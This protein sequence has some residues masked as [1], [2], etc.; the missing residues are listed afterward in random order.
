MRFT[1]SIILICLV[2]PV[3]VFAQKTDSLVKKDFKPSGIR[4]GTDVLS[5]VRNHLDESFAGWEVSADVDF[6]RYYLA[7]DIGRWERNFT[8]ATEQYN[9]NG[10]YW[11]AGV[12]VNFLKK[13]PEKNMLFL[14][15]RYASGA[16]DEH[17]TFALDD[18]WTSGTTSYSNVNTKAS[19]AEI[20]GGLRI[21]LWKA[22]WVGYTARYK[23]GLNTKETSN[24]VPHDV[25]GFGKTNKTA[26]WGFNYQILF[27]VPF[28][29]EGGRN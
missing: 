23:F 4:I 7:F 26:T 10:S 16:F 13:D 1:S 3:M 6:Y 11:R 21:K 2:F 20:T 19:W 5:L 29:K 14:G 24:M 28:K 15:A 9:N 22:L 8:T 27:R 25:P 12:D 17:L 18:L